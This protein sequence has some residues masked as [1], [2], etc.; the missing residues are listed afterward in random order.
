MLIACF[1]NL[2]LALLATFVSSCIFEDLND[3]LTKAVI[4]VS[5]EEGQ[6]PAS[7]AEGRF[8]VNNAAVFFFN[9]NLQLDSVVQL[10]GEDIANRKPIE[11]NVRNG[12]FPHVVVWG[13]VDISEED[14]QWTP[15]LRLSDARIRMLEKDGYTLP[16]S[17]FYYGMRELT[18]EPVQEVVVSKWVG[19]VSTTV[20]GIEDAQTNVGDYYFTLESEYNSYDFYGRPQKGHALIKVD[21]ATSVSQQEVLLFHQP[22]NL[23][24]YPDKYDGNQTIRVSLFKKTP[25]GDVLIVSAIKNIEGDDIVTRIG[26]NTNVLIDLTDKGNIVVQIKITPWNYIY[27]W[28]W[29]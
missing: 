8:N 11:V 4:Y 16:A 2:L 3:C 6:T 18:A 1:R 23:V 7:S 9:E 27:Q 26:E 5:V 25:Q 20:R 28:V 29:W 22:V 17:K 19:R 15:G 12:K 13:N 14:S 24:A 10:T 21:A